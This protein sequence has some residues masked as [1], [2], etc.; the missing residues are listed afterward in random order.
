MITFSSLPIVSTLFCQNSK[1]ILSLHQTFR[2]SITP[3]CTGG[4]YHLPLI[5]SSYLHSL[6]S[7]ENMHG[8]GCAQPTALDGRYRETKGVL[9]IMVVS[10]YAERA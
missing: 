7:L 4:T 5:T 2:F 3:C 1:G 8:N 10:G 6:A 9:G